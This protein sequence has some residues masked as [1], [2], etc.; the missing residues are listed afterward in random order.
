MEKKQNDNCIYKNF[1]LEKK[2]FVLIND[3]IETSQFYS[4]IILG[5]IL[6]VW[7]NSKKNYCYSDKVITPKIVLV[8]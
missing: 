4:L 7:N 5:F 3:G 6:M 1:L 2:D 8:T